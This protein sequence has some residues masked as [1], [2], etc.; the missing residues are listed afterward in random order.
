MTKK[1][2][3]KTTVERFLHNETYGIIFC[4]LALDKVMSDSL[5]ITCSKSLPVKLLDER[6]FMTIVFLIGTRFRS[7]KISIR[8][9]WLLGLMLVVPSRLMRFEEVAELRLP[10]VR[11]V[12]RLDWLMIGRVSSDKTSRSTPL[13]DEFNVSSMLVSKSV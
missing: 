2:Q 5:P 3:K 7:A 6:V 10:L 12:I 8:E 1:K 9:V 13:V 4:I 11:M